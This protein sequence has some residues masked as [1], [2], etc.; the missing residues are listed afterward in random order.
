MVS[1]FEEPTK[2]QTVRTPSPPE[3]TCPLESLPLCSPHTSRVVP[4]AGLHPYEHHS[5][6]P[7]TGKC[8]RGPLS[9]RPPC[10]LVGLPDA[11]R[12]RTPATGLSSTTGPDPH[13]GLLLGSALDLPTR[14]RRRPTR[15]TTSSPRTT[16]GTLAAHSSSAPRLICRGS[17]W[18]TVNYPSAPL[19][20][21]ERLLS[22]LYPPSLVLSLPVRNKSRVLPWNAKRSYLTPFVPHPVHR[23]DRLTHRE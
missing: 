12:A 1:F 4:P 21:S 17:P 10:T 11:S 20:T 22:L 18:S 5:P 15:S 2:N 16:S 8:P 6:V 23:G 9:R 19:G 13:K 14:G 3:P 7:G